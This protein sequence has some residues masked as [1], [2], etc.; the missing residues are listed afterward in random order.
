MKFLSL[1]AFLAGF[2]LFSAPPADAQIVY[3]E[4]KL[5]HMRKAAKQQNKPYVIYFMQ[6][7]CGASLKVERNVLNDPAISETLK[8]SALIF[9]SNVK[10]KSGLGAEMRIKGTPT[11]IFFDSQGNETGR[12]GGVI[13]QQQL[14]DQLRKAERASGSR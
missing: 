6:P 12:H 13:S 2:L 4:G 14:L 5:N 11:M 9:Q 7:S 3:F 1:F 10:K 8:S